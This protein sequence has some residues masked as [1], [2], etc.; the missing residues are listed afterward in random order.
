MNRQQ[1][2][3]AAGIDTLRTLGAGA[4]DPGRAAGAME[5]HHGALGS[6]GVDHILGQLWNRPQLGRRDRSLIVVAFL[7]ASGAAGEEELAFH[8]RG[9]VNHGL[10]RE[11]VEEIVIQV[12]AYAGF[13]AAMSASRIV[14][15]AWQSAEADAEGAERT[16]RAPAAKLDDEQRWAAAN[17]VRG[18]MWAGRNDP[19]PAAD[20]AAITDFLG[21]VGELAFDFAFGEVWSRDVFSRRDRSMVTVAILAML[22]CADELQIHVRAALNH[23]CTRTEIEEI[24]VQLS[25]YGGFPRAVEGMRTVRQIFERI[26]A[27]SRD[28]ASSKANASDKANN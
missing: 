2:R 10:S 23:G 11:Q 7:A 6:F 1:D 20:R 5:K 18:R 12:A 22:K 15:R 17:E 3:R 19:D 8:A 27:R 14:S 28:D 13:P 9:A 16:R 4:F 25:G 24:M 26:D 21:G